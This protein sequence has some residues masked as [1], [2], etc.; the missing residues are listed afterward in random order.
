[1]S[2]GAG[3]NAAVKRILKEAKEMQENASSEFTAAPLED[4]FFEWHFTLRGPEG[5]AFAGGR[6]HGRITLPQ[7]Y[8][9]RP[10]SIFLLTPNGRFEVGKK[11]C[12]SVSAH[13]PESWQPAW[14]IRTIITALIAFFPSKA[15]G[16]LAALDY[17]AEERQQLARRSLSWR[18]PRCSA[19]MSD[20]LCATVESSVV[21]DAPLPPPPPEL[22]FSVSADGATAQ[23]GGGREPRASAPPDNDSVAAAASH[24]VQ[25]TTRVEGGTPV[26]EPDPSPTLAPCTPDDPAAS[27]MRTR[28]MPLGSSTPA[29]LSD[30]HLSFLA[31][32]LAVAIVALLAMKLGLQF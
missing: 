16:A 10:P 5:T 18:C 8:P 19:C 22:C 27:S 30:A 20:V 3:S 21:A 15:E 29:L 13:H 11:I 1:M 12:L 9:F 31:V 2:S 26:L 14:G 25:G 28:P 7:E 6:F 24:S 4:D 23:G 17:T 32:A